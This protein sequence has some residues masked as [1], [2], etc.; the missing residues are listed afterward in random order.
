MCNNYSK[1]R[2]STLFTNRISRLFSL[3]QQS[4]IWEKTITKSLA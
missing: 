3:L 4:K 2:E 1:I